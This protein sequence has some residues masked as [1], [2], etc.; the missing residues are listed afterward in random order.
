MVG[1]TA[2]GAVLVCVVLAAC[3]SHRP[4]P[5]D[6]T[7]DQPNENAAEAGTSDPLQGFN[8]AMQSFNDTADRWV[9]KPV[10][11]GYRAVVPSLLRRGI[12][13]FYDNLTYPLVVVNQFLQGKPTLGFSDAG[14]FVMNSTLGIFGFFD[15]ATDAGLQSHDE[16]FGQTFGK[17]G[18]ASGPYL[19]LPLLGPSDVRDGAG[20]LLNVWLNPMRYVTDDERTRYALTGLYLIQTRASLLDAEQLIS[21]DRYIFMRDAYLQRRE[22]LIKD[23]QVQDE[24]L[25]DDWE[26]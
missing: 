25:D 26:E 16:D 12:G 24:F 21:G 22:Y 17:W 15:P 9:L 11:K 18:I 20:S 23:G 7:A 13:N 4:V 1:R 6:E 2:L 3:S 10:A 19:V 14:R 5:G 8:R